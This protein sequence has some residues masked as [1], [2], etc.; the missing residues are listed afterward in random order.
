V[1]VLRLDH[2]TIQVFLPGVRKV[3]AAR[4]S[5]LARFCAG[6]NDGNYLKMGTIK[7]N[8][9]ADEQNYLKRRSFHAL[10]NFRRALDS[11]ASGL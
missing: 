6:L 9:F 11:L 2:A 8:H 1:P 10:D 5:P 7:Y 3:A 4:R